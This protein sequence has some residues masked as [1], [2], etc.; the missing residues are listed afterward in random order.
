[1]RR[2]RPNAPVDDALLHRLRRAGAEARRLLPA[3]HGEAAQ[4]ASSGAVLATM[5]E[6]TGLLR[7]LLAERGRLGAELETIDRRTRAVSAYRKASGLRTL[8]PHVKRC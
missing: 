3:P 7:E 2:R 5:A 6:L 4:P 8:S 1:M